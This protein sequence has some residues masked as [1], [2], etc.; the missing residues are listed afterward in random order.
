MMH[1]RRYFLRDALATTAVAGGVV[2]PHALA[3]SPALARLLIGAPA[4]GAGDTRA[5][6]FCAASPSACA[7]AMRAARSW[8]TSQARVG[9]LR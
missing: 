9:R 3:Q 8:K 4:G 2:L 7:A 6:L 5:T 1:S